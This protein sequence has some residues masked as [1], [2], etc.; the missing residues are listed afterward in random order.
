MDRI[1][2]V[3]VA[4]SHLT[5]D[6][7]NAGVQHEA[8]SKRLRI[9]FDEGWDGYAKT[10]TWWD[11]LGQNPVKRVLTTDCLEDATKD[12]RVYLCPIPGEAM[13]EDGMC[14]FIIDGYSD[15]KRMRSVSDELLVSDAP[16]DENADEPA[17][18]TPSQAE[19]LQEQIDTIMDDIQN[20]TLGS[21]ASRRPQTPLAPLRPA[22]MRQKNLR[23]RRTAPRPLRPPAQPTRRQTGRPSRT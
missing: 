16:F 18:P 9:T 3:K 15:G 22:R 23:Q 17:D 10:V 7:R 6:N 12:T 20:V 13:T 21:V 1:I 19:Q 4:G 8:N 14:T 2:E 5:K 11:A